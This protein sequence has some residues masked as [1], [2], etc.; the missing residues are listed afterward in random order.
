MHT[1]STPAATRRLALARIR[2]WLIDWFHILLLPVLL[3]PVGVAMRWAGVE[4]SPTG[5]DIAAFFALVLP[6]TV[7]LAIRESRP[8]GTPGK[9]R[10][11]LR[12]I[13]DAT[14]ETPGLGRTLVRN[15]V[16][17]AI[18]WQLGHSVAF[19]FATL[20][21]AAP[22]ARLIVL[23]IG[24]YGLIIAHAGA[25]FLGR[26]RTLYDVAARTSVVPVVR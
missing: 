3:V 10:R 20:G 7:W 18:P 14:G 2:A 21:D 26:G 16:K 11:G 25:L 5:W 19:G 12:V 6:V 17:V 13:D 9:R 8:L 4:L 1:M 15:V 24:C 23:T 22:G